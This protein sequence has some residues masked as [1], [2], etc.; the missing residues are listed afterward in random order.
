MELNYLLLPHTAQKAWNSF[1]N[2]QRNGSACKTLGQNLKI[3]LYKDG[4]ALGLCGLTYTDRI[5]SDPVTP[6]HLSLG[7][8]FHLGM[9]SRDTALQRGFTCW[10]GIGFGWSF[11]ESSL[12]EEAV[13]MW[14]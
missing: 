12:G 3:L 10:G 14:Q 7:G 6:A 8:Y 1:V 9:A 11:G 4:N 5:A 13:E 2:E